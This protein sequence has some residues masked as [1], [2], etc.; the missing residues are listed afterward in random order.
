[1]LPER[2]VLDEANEEVVDALLERLRPLLLVP[3]VDVA[4]VNPVRRVLERVRAA[5]ETTG[6]V[7]V[8]VGPIFAVE[9][10]GWACW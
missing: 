1:M 3:R 8:L 5:V 10:M 4:A 7:E 9:A 6:A 2:P